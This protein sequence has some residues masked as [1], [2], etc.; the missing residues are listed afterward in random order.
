[1]QKNVCGFT[2]NFKFEKLEKFLMSQKKIHY[3]IY[4][5]KKTINSYR[6]RFFFRFR[7][8]PIFNKTIYI[9]RKNNYF[10]NIVE[11]KKKKTIDLIVS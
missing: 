4:Y 10:K 3:H 2:N 7:K 1:M 8:Y 11:L 6:F 5:R 9:F